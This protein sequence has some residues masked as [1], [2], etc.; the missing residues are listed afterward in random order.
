M[1]KKRE[2]GI[3]SLGTH[4][5]AQK[6][7]SVVIKLNYRREQK[8]KKKETKQTPNIYKYQEKLFLLKCQESQSPFNKVNLNE[9]WG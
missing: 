9:I 4:I 2:A 5:E 8:E 7:G 3:A 6:I 1:E